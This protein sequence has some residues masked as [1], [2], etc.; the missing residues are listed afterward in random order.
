MPCP[1]SRV[2][3]WGHFSVKMEDIYV[4]TCYNP[5][6]SLEYEN[7]SSNED[8]RHLCRNIYMPCS[9]CRVYR[10]TNLQWRWRHLCRN[11]LDV[12]L[13]VSCLSVSTISNGDED[14]YVEI[15]CYVLS[16]LPVSSFNGEYIF[17]FPIFFCVLLLS[18]QGIRLFPN[19]VLATQFKIHEKKI[20]LITLLQQIRYEPLKQPKQPIGSPK[21]EKLFSNTR[22][23]NELYRGV[24]YKCTT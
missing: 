10:G 15:S 6:S 8:G 13:P 23:Q 24:R 9:V 12:T 22:I 1:L 4:E 3:R 19:I 2:Y 18:L 5:T 21:T 20:F 14:I 11:I 16:P 17:N 7:T